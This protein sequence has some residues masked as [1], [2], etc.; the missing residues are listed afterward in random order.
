MPVFHGPRKNRASEFARGAR[1]KRI[2]K[3]D[4]YMAA[5]SGTRA[6]EN[7]RH[8]PLPAC[9]QKCAR[10]VSPCFLVEIHGEKPTGFVREKR[11]N[12]N[13]FF[14]EKMIL[15]NEF[16]QGE[17]LPACV[18]RPSSDPPACLS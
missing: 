5:I 1:R 13:G 4:P 15:D 6:L 11:I 14:P 16:G 7:C 17:E 2:F 12:A 18:D 9:V 10:V 8:A 3:E